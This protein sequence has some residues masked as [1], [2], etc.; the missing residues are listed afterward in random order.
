MPNLDEVLKQIEG[1]GAKQAPQPSFSD[2]YTTANIDRNNDLY[3]K[4]FGSTQ[5]RVLEDNVKSY[6]PEQLQRIEDAG[7]TREQVA[8]SGLDIADMEDLYRKKQADEQSGFQQAFN[9]LVQLLGNE[10]AIGTVK[11]VADLIDAG[12]NIFTKDHWQ[13]PVSGFLESCQDWIREQAPIHT[14]ERGDS[15]W[16]WQGVEQIGSVAS[17]AIPTMGLAKGAGLISK[18]LKLSD[19]VSDAIKLAG[20]TERGAKLIERG[21]LAGKILKYPNLTTRNVGDAAS[22]LLNATFSRAMENQQEANEVYK[23]AVTE[24]DETLRKYSPEDFA[25]FIQLN[26]EYQS[27]KDDMGNWNI[28]AIAEDMA[29][30]AANATFDRDMVLIGMDLLQWNTI[31]KVLKGAATRSLSGAVKRANREAINNIGKATTNTEVEAIKKGFLPTIGSKAKQAGLWVK[32]HSKELSLEMLGEGFEEGYQG[33]MQGVAENYYQMALDESVPLRGLDSYLSD[34]NIWDQFFWGAMGGLLG[35]GGMKLLHKGYTKHELK[36]QLKDKKI[37]PSQYSEY[38]KSDEEKGIAEINGRNKVLTQLKD[39]LD[40]IDRNINPFATKED[41]KTINTVEEQSALKEHAINEAVTELVMNAADAGTINLLSE[42]INASNVKEQIDNDNTNTK[43]LSTKLIDGFNKAYQKYQENVEDLIHNTS[44]ENPEL[45][46]AMARDLTRRDMNIEYIQKILNENIERIGFIEGQKPSGNYENWATAEQYLQLLIDGDIALDR[47]EEDYKNGKITSTIYNINKVRLNEL[48]D[49]YK[50]AYTNFLQTAAPNADINKINAAISNNDLKSLK[51]INKDLWYDEDEASSLPKAIVNQLLDNIQ[52]KIVLEEQI[53]LRPKTQ[54]DFEQYYANFEEIAANVLN[55]KVNN[56]FSNIRNYLSN[57]KDLNEAVNNLFNGTFD[58]TVSNEDKKKLNDAMKILRIGTSNQNRVTDLFKRMVNQLEADRARLEENEGKG[59]NGEQTTKNPVNDGEHVDDAPSPK[60]NETNDSSK[61]EQKEEVSD[62]VAAGYEEVKISDDDTE[63]LP[64][65]EFSEEPLEIDDGGAKFIGESWASR[66]YEDAVREEYFVRDIEDAFKFTAQ[67]GSIPLSVVIEKGLGSQEYKDFLEY[68]VKYLSQNYGYLQ[69]EIRPELHYRFSNYL[70]KFVGS[71]VNLSKEAK[72]NIYKMIVQLNNLT[73]SFVISDDFSE[74]SPKSDEQ[75]TKEI[76]EFFDK[77]FELSGYIKHTNNAGLKVINLEGLLQDLIKL[78]EDGTYT[79]EQIC[80]I[81]NNIANYEKFSKNNGQ[82]VF[83]NKQVLNSF[84]LDN[85]TVSKTLNVSEFINT[86]HNIISANQIVD[87]HI[88]FSLSNLLYKTNEKGE[89][90]LDIQALNNARGKQLYIKDA[91][92]KSISLYYI[93]SKG[94]EQEVGYLSKVN[95]SANNNELSIDS[96][97]NFV[98]RVRQTD[99]KIH[100]SNIFLE[101]QI[102]NI[103]D[104][105]DNQKS[106]LRKTFDFFYTRFAVNYPEKYILEKDIYTVSEEALNDPEFIDFVDS[107]RDELDLP[108]LNLNVSKDQLLSE[109]SAALAEIAKKVNEVLFYPYNTNREMGA[110]SSDV[111][112]ASFDEYIA[113]VYKNYS[114][115]LDYQNKLKNGENIA[116]FRFISSDLSLLRY[117]KDDSKLKG[118]STIGIKGSIKNHPFIMIDENGNVVVEGSNSKLNNVP[119]WAPFTAGILL[120]SKADAPMV[121]IFRGANRISDKKLLQAINDELDKLLINYL[122]ATGT[123]VEKAYNELLDFFKNITYSKDTSLF[124]GWKLS[125]NTNGT[126]DVYRE[127]GSVDKEGHATREVLAR[128]YK[129][130]VY[131]DKADG[132]Y[133]DKTTGQVVEPS[134]FQKHY[135][136]RFSFVRKSGNSKTRV[137]VTNSNATKV[138]SEIKNTFINNLVFN[139]LAINGIGKNPFSTKNEGTSF[140]VKI[141]NYEKT[142]D[143]YADWIVQNNAFQTTHQGTRTTTMFK[144]DSSSNA[145]YVEYTGAREDISPE[146]KRQIVG[147]SVNFEERG[148]KDGD[149]VT[150]EDLLLDAGYS[151]EELKDYDPVLKIL[152]AAKV[153]LDLKD[154][155]NAKAKHTVTKNGSIVQL[156]QK[157]VDIINVDKRNAIRLLIHEFVHKAAHDENFFTDKYSKARVEV[158]IDTYEQFHKYLSQH[159]ELLANNPELDNFATNF[160][161]KQRDN[162]NSKDDNKRIEAANEW[163]A[164]VMSNSGIFNLLNDI[165]YEGSYKVEDEGTNKTLLQRILDE[166]LKLFSKL[167]N[168]LNQINNQNILE[169][170]QKALGS[171]V[172]TSITEVTPETSSEQQKEGSEEIIKENTGNNIF[173]EMDKSLDDIDIEPEFSELSGVFEETQFNAYLNNTENNPY[174]LRLAPN[175]DT[176]LQS[177]PTKQRAAVAS[178]LTKGRVKYLCQ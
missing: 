42:Y 31:N 9:A 1:G 139:R 39:N 101:Q 53:A 58:D 47:L 131:R 37:T 22:T 170:F 17:L 70:S 172:Y 151:K 115:T 78:S 85:T 126:F 145:V 149:T 15:G 135:G 80:E 8:K 116:G 88:H 138:I 146:E 66:R 18:G 165:P 4:L 103:I 147:I 108:D 176:Y 49:I 143:N 137:T 166:V 87:N 30:K 28:G 21:G 161:N 56:A 46:K 27:Y 105:A 111:L 112:H 164:E 11:G 154:N 24:I 34:P 40:Y 76:E 25:R 61:G 75:I 174:G 124:T 93:D 20:A 71:N 95:K 5:E 153:K 156:T 79:F 117:S 54:Q 45:L 173:D 160:E 98:H 129:Y 57:A 67:N 92:G 171:P 60:P 142:F 69:A 157:G 136:T 32:D 162:I 104:A 68:A 163:M 29:S 118:I 119:N 41:E 150:S 13:G 99:G 73:S 102:H 177:L 35:G 14:Y 106:P 155:S 168:R 89:R 55:T 3:D 62:D 7:F 133:K 43:D 125:V 83:E 167:H 90:V 23:S 140:T 77:Y 127:T 94:N 130:D 86:I 122:N 33:T 159:P 110:I 52:Q 128:F 38:I 107:L 44:V 175:I 169:Q 132:K 50:N 109:N 178:E 72:N 10:V 6:T 65:D 63:T 123:D 158:L 64:V 121:A 82:Y 141:G 134:D 84:V 19:K 96:R 51:S 48:K 16:W 120:E 81:I 97:N 91:G 59:N 100:M 36:K 2:G 148:V 152:K 26:P 113:K 74:I 12:V 144:V 114:Q